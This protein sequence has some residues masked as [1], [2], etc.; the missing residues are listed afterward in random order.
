M[1]LAIKR[2][3]SMKQIKFQ[4]MNFTKGLENSRQMRNEMCKN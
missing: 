1:K 4:T 2:N 3:L